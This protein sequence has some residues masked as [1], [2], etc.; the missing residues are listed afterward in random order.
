MSD[1][2]MAIDYET[3]LIS[4]EMPIPKPVCLSFFDGEETGLLVGDDIEPFLEK[5]LN[6]NYLIV[7]QNATFELLVT[8]KYY[9]KLKTKIIESLKEGRWYCTQLYQTLLD[10]IAEKPTYASSLAQLVLHYFNEDL[11]TE[12]SDPD[13]WRLRYSELESVPLLAWP[14]RA[15]DY[16]INDSIWAYKVRENQ[17]KINRLVG[18]KEHI[19]ASFA[20]NWM[21]TRGMLTD[22]DRVDL[23]SDEIDALLNPTYA[24]LENLGFM[25]RKT[26]KKT[27]KVKVS[28]N[29]KGLQEYVKD[30]FENLMKTPAGSIQVSKEALD[31]YCLEKEDKIIS[32]FRG[33]S[34]YEKA[35]TAF[36]SR[37]KTADPVIRTSYNA[38]VR[39]GRTSSRTTSAYPSVNIQQMPRAL[40]GVTYDI[41]NCFVARPGFKFVSIDYNNLELLCCAQQLFLEYGWSKMKDIINSGDKPTDLHSVFACELMSRKVKKDIKYEEFVKNKKQE[42]YKPY[43]EKG[44]PVTLGKPGGLGLDTMRT[45]FNAAGI[46][47]DFQVIMKCKTEGQARS[48]VR[49]F[50]SEYPRMR[51]SRTG[52][53]EWSIV[54]DELVELNKILYDLYPE[55]ER[56]LKEGHS[57]Y[58]NGKYGWEKNDWGEWEK[59]ELYRYK[60]AGVERNYCTYTALCNGKLM[61]GPSASGAKNA[62]W[63]AVIEYLDSDEVFPVA[64]IHDEIL[65]EIRENDNFISNIDRCAEIMVDSMA[66]VFPDVR[67]AVEAEVF[68]YWTKSGNDWSRQYWKDSGSEELKWE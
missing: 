54:L 61:Q 10:N 17:L 3:Y 35:K 62:V 36:L 64:F 45:Q 8:F 25:N 65:F 58:K 18:Y 24:W 55:L 51:V 5:I 48:G 26:V 68:K 41:R 44:K 16:A 4:N 20:L 42:E 7:A 19:K 22:T 23:L 47:L 13:A 53:K 30:N 2:I 59:Q 66:E 34:V 39:S 6:E 31:F 27:G 67:I 12:K 57:K 11:S 32:A 37:L 28:K 43:R 9:P 49:K 63:N 52:F 33:L 46:K 50:G 56:F 14:K 21:A 60:A 40:K 15:V 1:K 29:I 38:I